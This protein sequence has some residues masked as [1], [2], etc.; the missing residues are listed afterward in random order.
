MWMF[1]YFQLF[2]IGFA[3]WFSMHIQ[4]LQLPE[5]PPGGGTM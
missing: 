4:Q 3:Y 1:T 2:G 5:K